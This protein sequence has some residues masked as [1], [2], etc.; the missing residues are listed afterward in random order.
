[1]SF[2]FSDL[3]IPDESGDNYDY[4]QFLSEPIY[5]WLNFPDA[6]LQA[7]DDLEEEKT[8]NEKLQLFNKHNQKIQLHGKKYYIVVDHI[9]KEIEINHLHNCKYPIR[10]WLLFLNA[11][12]SAKSCAS[13][14]PKAAFI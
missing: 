9:A 3:V 4:S 2:D 6:A 14:G 5:D 7:C 13:C 10:C 12:K 8:K 11:S 1:M